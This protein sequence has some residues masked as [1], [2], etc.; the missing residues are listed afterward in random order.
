MSHRKIELGLSTERAAVHSTGQCASK[1]AALDTIVV[2]SLKNQNQKIKKTKK[3]NQKTKEGKKN[4]KNRYFRTVLTARLSLAN[5]T[6]WGYL[7]FYVALEPP[8]VKKTAPSQLLCNLQVALDEPCVRPVSA[9][10]N[11][12]TVMH[13]TLLTSLAG[14]SVDPFV[15][16]SCKLG[17]EEKS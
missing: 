10:H 11:C 12:L 9:V 14:L 4:Q 17:Y 7:G 1:V 6:F 13:N 8:F 2:G 3:Q 15:T 16:S 5:N